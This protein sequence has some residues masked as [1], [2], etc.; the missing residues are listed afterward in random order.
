MSL[1]FRQG[2]VGKCCEALSDAAE[3]KGEDVAATQDTTEQNKI[4][5]RADSS[6]N[7]LRRVA[8]RKSS[9]NAC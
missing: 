5:E 3:S 8:V 9:R 2:Q 4:K 7:D 1:G 6:I